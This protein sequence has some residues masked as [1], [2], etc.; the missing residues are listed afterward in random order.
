MCVCPFPYPTSASTY[1]PLLPPPQP[2]LRLTS[3]QILTGSADRKI[4]LFNPAKAASSS[5]PLPPSSIR[6]SSTSKGADTASSPGLVQTFSAH[7]YSVLDIAVAADNA[8]FASVG[9]DRQVFLW[10]VTTAQTLRRWAGHGGRVNA[11]A[12]G[13]G[14]G[15]WEEGKGAE[16]V[17]VSG[18][19]FEWRMGDMGEM[20]PYSPGLLGG[21]KERYS[22]TNNR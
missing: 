5:T 1:T 14:G 15:G 19:C 8:R 10:D 6:S 18:E 4:R 16:G 3:L 12:F 21:L 20:A 13:G 2:Y 7:G 11:V 9:G 17:V 22:F